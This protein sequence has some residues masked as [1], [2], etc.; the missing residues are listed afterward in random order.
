MQYVVDVNTDTC[1]NNFVT[2][3][4]IFGRTT[5]NIPFWRIYGLLR[6][7]ST[8]EQ[9]LHK[10]IQHLFETGKYYYEMKITTSDTDSF[11]GIFST[12]QLS[13]MLV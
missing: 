1:T 5:G 13:Y 10:F 2:V 7:N 11:I 8:T 9:G 6:A 4:S 12:E 3:V